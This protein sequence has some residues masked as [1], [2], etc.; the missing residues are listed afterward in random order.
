MNN[1]IDWFLYI[2]ILIFLTLIQHA[3]IIS[4]YIDFY[5]SRQSTSFSF[6]QITSS[7]LRIKTIE[8]K[9]REVVS[10]EKVFH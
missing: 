4:S 10:F 5:N 3:L 1:V 6:L 7:L 2:D 8:L 9:T